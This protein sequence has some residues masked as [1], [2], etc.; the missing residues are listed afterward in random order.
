MSKLGALARTTGIALALLTAAGA[1]AAQQRTVNVYNWSDY[2]AEEKLEAFTK[3]TGVKINYDVFDSQP[4]LESKLTTGK[5]GY[6]VVVP[7]A[8]P[9]MARQIKAGLYQK[10]DKTKLKNYG[11]VDPDIM[12]ALAEADAGNEYAVPWMWG[13]NGIGYNVDRV[14]KIMPDAPVYSL[15]LLFDPEIV[16]KFKGCGVTVLDEPVDMIAIALH[17]L[18]RNPDSKKIEDLEAATDLFMKIRPS[19]KKFHSSEYINGLANGDICIAY[20]YSGDVIQSAT[21]AEEAKR[22]YK[23]AYSIPTEG[24]QIWID[25]FAIPK[26]S[27]N[28]E[29]A[30]M[31]IDYMLRPDVA[32]ASSNFVGY[33]NGNKA[34]TALLDESLR[35]N[36]GV[37]P[38]AE[39]R[40]KFF[41]VT[42]ADRDFERART[43]AWTRIKTG[44]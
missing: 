3:E 25:S 10:L 8:Q 42:P 23:V 17:Y 22:P 4:L 31:F 11:N 33:A 35:S 43:R 21:R 40:A 38:P 36:P 13:T 24:A 12:K 7:T 2:V 27:P 26:D 5:S 44:R 16:S 30:H 18:G 29:L 32:A 6:D 37:Y 15:K 34:A 9:Y 20:G 19:I 1:A 14:K 41:G 28:P 39:V